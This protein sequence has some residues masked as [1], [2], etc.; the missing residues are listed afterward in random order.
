[1]YKRCALPE[2]VKNFEQVMASQRYHIL[3]DSAFAL[4]VGLMKPFSQD[5]ASEDTLISLFNYQLSSVR[6]LIECT[7]GILKERFRCLKIPLSFRTIEMNCKVTC[8]CVLL[9]NFLI[10]QKDAHNPV[11][12]DDVSKNL[13]CSSGVSDGLQDPS[14]TKTGYE[15]R[16][17]LLWKLT[18]WTRS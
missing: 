11:L 13:T 7:F 2:L 12:I 5:A 3:G 9:H 8:A 18:G 17:E 10:D 1:M 15:K 4:T 14:S 16:E 6:M